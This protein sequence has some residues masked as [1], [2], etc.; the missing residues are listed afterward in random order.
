[1]LAVGVSKQCS[2]CRFSLQDRNWR[3]GGVLDPSKADNRPDATEVLLLVNPTAGAR[4]R[5][6]IVK[7]TA[8]NL[9]D[10]GYQTKIVSDLQELSD[11]A[12][13]KMERKT[14]RAVVTAGGDG[15]VS[16]VAHRTPM[17][18]PIA[19]L[20]LG[21]ENLL[22]K[23][24]KIPSDPRRVCQMID[25]GT[26]VQLDTGRANGR[27]F[28]LMVGCGFDAEVVRRVDQA[29]TGH[30]T[31]FSYAK[32]ILDAIR[33][34]QYPELRIYSFCAD[35]DGEPTHQVTARWAFVANLPRYAR[36]LGVVPQACG[37]D[38][39]LDACTF[40]RGSLFRGLIYLASIVLR[41]HQSL[42]DC[43]TLQAERF[44]IEADVEVPYQ[45]DGD[46]GGYLPVAI[47]V[48][49]RRLTVVVPNA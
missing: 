30:I 20:P 14:L 19:I 6:S 24:L 9:N 4:S 8:R 17:G 12:A 33:S 32:P 5:R 49:P 18:T 42:N 38:G 44:R 26:T 25:E 34:Y 31:H 10:L 37:T 1:M 21:T 7:Q 35:G 23:Y 47:E 40:R 43:V 22:A 2:L 41:C 3:Q 27:L 48:V 45:L 29:R 36:G 28:L 46:P 16:A 11:L 15:T 13:E 39:L